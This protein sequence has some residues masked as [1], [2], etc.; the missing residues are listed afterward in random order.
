VPVHD[1]WRR[2]PS[3]DSP[4]RPAPGAA[5]KRGL[6]GLLQG[7]SWLTFGLIDQ[8]VFAVAN[9]ANTLLALALL[10]RSVA[11]VMLLSLSLGY[12]VIGVSRAFVG[13]VLL[14][15]ASRYDDD[16]RG[17]LVR[18][19]VTAALTNSGIAAVILFLVWLLLPVKGG[20]DLR[21]LIWLVPFLP[22]LLLHDTGRYS[23]LAARTPKRALAIDAVWVG[24]QL[25]AVAVMVAVGL[26][27]AGG[28][29]FCWGLGAT[30]GA[31]AFLVRTRTRP[32]AGNPRAWLA[33]T[34][35]LS[36]WFTA[37]ALVGQ[38][39][40]QLVGFLVTS[41]LSAKELSGLRGAQTALLQ[42]VQSFITAVMSLLVPRTSRLA[43]KVSL[44][45]PDG[46]QAAHQLRR[47]TRMLALGFAAL[48]LVMIAIVV[49]VAR[50]V[51]V[52]IPKFADIA[53]LAL[54][55]AIQPG[56][57]LV[58]LPFSAALRGMH[59]APLLFVQYLIFTTTS[60]IGLVVGADAGRLTGAAWGLTVGSAVG[61]VAQIALYWWAQRRLDHPDGE[62]AA[63]SGEGPRGEGE[64]A[65][66]PPAAG[67]AE[68]E[69]VSPARELTPEPAAPSLP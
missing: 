4:A 58:Q 69:G 59:R 23:F 65:S 34:R 27:S 20:V 29:L 11:G 38:L 26:T 64:D 14:A 21:Y 52:R 3:T 44:A 2:A 49:P 1:R 54:P 30:A 19:G 16:R 43:A 36:G 18:N 8:V 53:P 15:L 9:A 13:E 46:R 48:A 56:I 67:A 62:R 33:E 63:P 68:R 6:A 60:L 10:N 25:L 41:R 50:T 39:Q 51:L 61:L 47:Q 45:G 31:T 35:H 24:T 22:S 7:R 28:L 57:Y 42:P 32:W 17:R 37:T 5:G 40:P 12:F 55:I 66:P